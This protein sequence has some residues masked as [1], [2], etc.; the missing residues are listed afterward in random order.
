MKK[1]E[2]STFILNQGRESGTY[3]LGKRLG[4]KESA[5]QHRKLKFFDPEHKTN[6][7]SG[8]TPERM[9]E[10][11]IVDI[12]T[13]LAD[14]GKSQVTR[15]TVA[16]VHYECAS[17]RREFSQPIE[18]ADADITEVQPLLTC[19]AWMSL[20]IDIHRFL[21]AIYK[22]REET[23]WNKIYISS[24]QGEE[25]LQLTLCLYHQSTGNLIDEVCDR[26]RWF[27]D[28]DD[29]EGTLLRNKK[30]IECLEEARNLFPV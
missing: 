18:R 2:S 30:I 14:R 26:L 21:L 9:E 8:A 5:Q 27:K 12:N 1:P 16:P 4:V 15:V 13:F 25:L 28:Q 22:S 11:I 6:P 19:K 17:E 20:T 23:A 10:A 3:S 7:R 24:K 29:G